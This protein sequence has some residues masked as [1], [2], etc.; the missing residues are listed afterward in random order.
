[1]PPLEWSTFWEKIIPFSEDDEMGAFQVA[2]LAVIVR[3]DQF[4]L[5]R[6]W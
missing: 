3:A 4:L 1:M 2:A 6:S 5:V